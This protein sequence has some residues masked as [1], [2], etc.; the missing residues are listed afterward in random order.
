MF[1]GYEYSAEVWSHFRAPRNAGVFPAGMSGVVAGAAGARQHGRAVEFQ[2]QVDTAGTVA[3][4]RYR[5][6]GCPAT[7]A[8]C[9]MA[10]EA[11]KGMPL[12]AAA[13]YS[14]VA[15]AERLG[16]AAEKRAAA[17]VVE[18]AIRTAVARYNKN[19][20][21]QPAALKCDTES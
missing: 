15:L 13:G 17:I 1:P 19:L 3:D 9:S 4:C 21:S 8:L 7:I 18:D 20:R 11:L 16:L 10:S 14:V 2:L 12:P 6:F 5:V